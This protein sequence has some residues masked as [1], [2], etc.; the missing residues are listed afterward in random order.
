M[1]NNAQSTTGS[2]PS[3]FAHGDAGIGRKSRIYSGRCYWGM[4]STRDNMQLNLAIVADG[5]GEVNQGQIAARLAVDT[6]VNT[7]KESTGR[8]IPFMLGRA[9]GKANKRIHRVA[10]KYVYRKKMSTSVAVAAIYNQQLFIANVG[11]CR[12]YLIRDEMI[13]QLTRDHIWA[14]DQI[15]SGNITAIAALTDPRAG[16]LSRSVGRKP[17]V[18]VDLGLY[19]RGFADENEQIYRNQGLQLKPNDFLLVCSG[20]LTKLR[21][22][23]LGYYV[24]H[25][26]I[27]NSMGTNTPEQAAKMLVSFAIGRNVAD[28]VSVV[29]IKI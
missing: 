21:K 2:I 28:D 17:K 16:Q 4:V 25:A 18:K 11:G 26:E 12:I 27:I 8:N 1:A 9:T 19:I 5:D 6:I 24:D 3:G 15:R 20:G 14:H 7:C 23:G 29:V 10:S 22:D 13:S